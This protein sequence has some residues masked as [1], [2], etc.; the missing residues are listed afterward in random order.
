MCIVGTK[1]AKAQ[2]GDT[3]N[4]TKVH[5]QPEAHRPA[6]E[7]QA[8]AQGKHARVTA[9]RRGR[10]R[11]QAAAPCHAANGSPRPNEKLL[12]ALFGPDEDTAWTQKVGSLCS[13]PEPSI[14]SKAE[15]EL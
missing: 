11:M 6:V 15:P 3:E 8:T 14:T 10:P 7:T 2:R 9:Q 13:Y 12:F 4:A 5:E 1:G